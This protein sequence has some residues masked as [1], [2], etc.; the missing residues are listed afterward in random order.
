MI[1]IMNSIKTGIKDWK[2]KIAWISRLQKCL[3]MGKFDL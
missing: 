2:K 3:L 1:A